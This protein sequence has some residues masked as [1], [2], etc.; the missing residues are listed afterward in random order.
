MFSQARTTIKNIYI[1]IQP[2]ENFPGKPKTY[3][4]THMMTINLYR[5]VAGYRIIRKDNL[6]SYNFT[7][8]HIHTCKHTH[9]CTV[10]KVLCNVEWT[11]KRLTWSEPNNALCFA[12]REEYI[13]GVS[14]NSSHLA[15]LQWWTSGEESQGWTNAQRSPWS[16][17]QCAS[18]ARTSPRLPHLPKLGVLPGM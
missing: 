8:M 14:F 13:L 10:C 9:T 3:P 1:E 5:K 11:R 18:S 4:W 12:V 2:T 15:T 17:Q 16:T 7:E 6:C